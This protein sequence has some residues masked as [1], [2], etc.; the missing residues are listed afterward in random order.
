MKRKPIAEGIKTFDVLYN[1]REMQLTLIGA[2]AMAY[3]EAEDC[4]QRMARACLKYPG[5]SNHI[6]TRIGGTEGLVAITMAA[7]EHLGLKEE[8]KRTIELALT[9]EG[10]SQLKTYRDA[11]IHSRM[12]SVGTSIGRIPGRQNQPQDVL[13]TETALARLFLKLSPLARE[14]FY[15]CDV[16]DCSMKL[17]FGP[18]FSGPH[19]LRLERSIQAA[20]A[21]AQL[22]QRQR[23][24]IP[25]SP[26][27][28]DEPTVHEFPAPEDKANLHALLR[29]SARKTPRTKREQSHPRARQPGQKPGG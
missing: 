13:L 10:F 3:N 8:A 7:L 26:E 21:Q 5:D 28:P 2:V 18:R 22:S 14:L 16:I 12:V 23:R 29:D 6:V 25:P 27:F 20:L 15:L 4:L 1:F 17:H 24:A 11:V 9:G 19:K